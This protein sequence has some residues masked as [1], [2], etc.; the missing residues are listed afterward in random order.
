MAGFG[1]AQL[2][3]Y[4]KKLQESGYTI[5]VYTQDTSAK[6]TTRSLNTI[7]SP[8]TYFANDTK[9]LSNNTTCIWIYYSSLKLTSDNQIYVGIANMDI[10]TGRTSVFEFS[11]EYHHNPTTYDELERYVSIYNPS[12]CIFISNL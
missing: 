1:L 5:A 10:Y 12:E 3:K 9:S 11:K 8:G 7:F 6:N 4:V 2:E